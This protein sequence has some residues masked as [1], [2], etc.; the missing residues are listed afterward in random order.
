MA[1]RDSFKLSIRERQ[2]RHFSDNFKKEKVRLI[3]RG[4]IKVSDICKTYH[5]SPTAVYKW[6]NLFGSEPKIEK[7]IV[8]N[9]S[10]TKALLDMQKRLAELE[11]LLGQKQIELEFYKKMVDLAEDFYDID[12]KKNSSIRP[13]DSSGSTE[14]NTPSV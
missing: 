5:V 6:I 7:L 14:T 8:E 1:T 2:R 12:I 4:S 10:E 11:R 13:S 9:N 3:E